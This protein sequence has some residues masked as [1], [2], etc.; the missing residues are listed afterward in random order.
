MLIARSVPLAATL[1]NLA[2]RR[3]VF[4]SERDFQVALAWEVHIADPHMD[5]YLETRPAKRVHLDL[6]FERP[7]L[8][9]Y[10]AIELKYFTRAW[11]GPVRG[12]QYDLKDQSAHD[13][14]R[15]GVVK[16]IWRV[17]E[18]VRL[19]PGSNGAVIALTNDERYWNSS[20]RSTASDAAF[21]IGEGFV[22]EGKREW[23]RP[24]ANAERNVTLELRESYE[25]HWSEFSAFGDDGR[26]RQLVVEVPE[27][28]VSPTG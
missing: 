21:R 26:L 4:H 14:G 5:V 22:L 20:M 25:M 28:T 3:P 10:T 12:Q 16:D 27:V 9:S 6:A 19:R 1:A 8:E 11:S 2:A 17:E 15:Y 18:F 24:L 13:Y 7:D 23:G